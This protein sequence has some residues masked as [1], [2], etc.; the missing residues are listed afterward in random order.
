MLDIRKA[1]EYNNK[2]TAV[3]FMGHGTHHEANASYSKLQD[4]LLSKGNDNYYIGTVEGSPALEDVIT[5]VKKN[6]YSKVVLQPLM[7]VAGDHAKL[8]ACI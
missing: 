1:K 8:E 6:G 4:E 3:V 2:D 5:A 7:V